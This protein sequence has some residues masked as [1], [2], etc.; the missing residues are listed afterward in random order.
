MFDTFPSG[1]KNQEGWGE[2]LAC[3]RCKARMSR[4][5]LEQHDRQQF[6]PLNLYTILLSGLN[7]E[8]HFFQPLL[9]SKQTCIY[10]ECREG[11]EG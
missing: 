11:G 9:C 3:L 5:H 2:E 10:T 1:V 4:I 7:D 6:I 8:L